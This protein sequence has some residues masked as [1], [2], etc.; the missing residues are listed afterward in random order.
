MTTTNNN[1]P[2]DYFEGWGIDPDADDSRYRRG[3]ENGDPDEDPEPSEYDYY[4]GRHGH[5]FEPP[6][7]EPLTE[8][9]GGFRGYR[10]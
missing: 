7:D 4:V 1:E 5:C 6:R 3:D 10:W 8:P 2:P 9:L